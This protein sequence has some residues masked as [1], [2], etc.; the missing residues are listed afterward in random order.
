MEEQILNSCTKRVALVFAGFNRMANEA[1]RIL[2]IEEYL[3]RKPANL[4]GGQ[5][6][7]MGRVLMRQPRAFLFDE[8]LSNVD[9]QLRVGS[10]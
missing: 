9:A 10:A 6:V 1:P 3:D 7:T 4:S 5:L 8:P 2:K